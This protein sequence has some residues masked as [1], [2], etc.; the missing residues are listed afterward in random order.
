[1]SKLRDV[2]YGKDIDPA[3]TD[4]VEAVHIICSF[5]VRPKLISLNKNKKTSYFSSNL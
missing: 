1:M 4:E 2:I 3:E 5:W